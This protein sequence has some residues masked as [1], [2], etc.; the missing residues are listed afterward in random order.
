MSFSNTLYPA[1]PIRVSRGPTHQRGGLKQGHDMHRPIRAKPSESSVSLSI[2]P[3]PIRL[4]PM[5]RPGASS[6]L[7]CA[8]GFMPIAIPLQSIA[9]R[10][11]RHGC[12]I[13]ASI[14]RTQQPTTCLTLRA[15]ALTG[16][17]CWETTARGHRT[18]ELAKVLSPSCLKA[19]YLN[20][21]AGKC[22]TWKLRSS[23]NYLYVDIFCR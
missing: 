7:L 1:K 2:A 21:G 15:S 8:S 19:I 18:F 22:C 16:T 17:R 10:S 9:P 11:G 4:A 13:T 12:I 6:R 20:G 23:N 5:A 14:G 3:G